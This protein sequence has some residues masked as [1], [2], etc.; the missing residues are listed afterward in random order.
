MI[1]DMIARLPGLTEVDGSISPLEE[2]DDSTW[3][4]K[5]GT[6]PVC[7]LISVDKLFTMAGLHIYTP[8]LADY[9]VQNLTP[10]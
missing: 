10:K 2:L 3:T 5:D 4:R 7:V 9:S 8:G 1:L 6:G